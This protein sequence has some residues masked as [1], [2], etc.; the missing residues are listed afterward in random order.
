MKKLVIAVMMSAAVLLSATNVNAK[1]ETELKDELTKTYT[2]GNEQVKL[3]SGAVT[4]LERYLDAY[5]VDGDDCD[6]ISVRFQKLLDILRR[7]GTS[8]PSELSKGAKIEIKDLVKEI[9]ANTSVKATVNKNGLTI[10]KPGTDEVFTELSDELVRYT[11]SNNNMIII[12]AGTVSLLG[13]LAVALKMKKV[14]A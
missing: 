4:Q 11:D 13:I 14:N 3:K 9:S 6:Y 2:I 12:I 8:R 10:Y 7:E 5:V 1:T